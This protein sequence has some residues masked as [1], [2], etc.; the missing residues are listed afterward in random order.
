MSDEEDPRYRF[1]RLG[2]PGRMRLGQGPIG[3]QGELHDYES[4][5]G[6]EPNNRRVDSD[7]NRWG[8]RFLFQINQPTGAKQAT[9]DVQT[10]I[11][12][13]TLKRTTPMNIQLRFATADVNGNP[14][15]PF[16]WRYPFTQATLTV[17]VRRSS[18]PLSSIIED[19]VDIV[20]SATPGSTGQVYAL[21]VVTTEKLS[22]TA[23]LHAGSGT[24]SLWVEAIATPVTRQAFRDEIRGWPQVHVFAYPFQ[25]IVLP[26]LVGRAD[27][28]QFMVTNTSTTGN[29]RL[30]FNN[31][32]GTGSGGNPSV[33]IPFTPT[34][35]A[36]YQSP[37][38]GFTGNVLGGWVGATDGGAVVTEGLYHVPSTGIAIY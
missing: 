19:T 11:D 37:I 20:D 31:A 34:G 32:D 14:V 12:I 38:G 33:I 13:R 6:D 23:N 8:G 35:S 29:L 17:V 15:M 7:A 21:D 9:S 28:A 25:N 22:V 16:V 10:L 4:F 26:F 1:P 30:F 36:F 3:P 2:Q 5:P 27:R 18:D 24:Q